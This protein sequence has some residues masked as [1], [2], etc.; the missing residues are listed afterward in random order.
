MT[1]PEFSDSTLTSVSE[2]EKEYKRFNRLNSKNSS[3]RRMFVSPAS[4]RDGTDSEDEDGLGLSNV[5]SRWLNRRG[6]IV[7]SEDSDEDT[8]H[9]SDDIEEG[10]GISDDEILSPELPDGI[11]SNTGNF[12]YDRPPGSRDRIPCYVPS[13]WEETIFKCNIRGCKTQHHQYHEHLLPR[14]PRRDKMLPDIREVHYH[15]KWKHG[16]AFV[17]VYDNSVDNLKFR[18]QWAKKLCVPTDLK[19]FEEVFDA[20]FYELLPGKFSFKT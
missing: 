6:G 13:Y 7:L 5:S 17:F 12:P 15:P 18:R 4:Q 19:T 11:P 10:Y 2:L 20:G 16:R 3:P 1:G 8:A 9:L 14:S